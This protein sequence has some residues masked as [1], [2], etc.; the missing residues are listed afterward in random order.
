V[1]PEELGPAVLHALQE[2]DDVQLV[3]DVLRV[4]R[5]R[6]EQLRLL[7]QREIDLLPRHV[8]DSGCVL[9]SD[10]HDVL[11]RR[12]HRVVLRVR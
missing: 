7:L 12:K 6:R 3:S 11:C 1:H 10:R 9:L 8:V 4:E 5:S 2:R